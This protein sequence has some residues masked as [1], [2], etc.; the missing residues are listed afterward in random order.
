MISSPRSD[1]FCDW[2]DV[3]CSPDESFVQR[4]SDF[5]DSLMCPVAFSDDRCVSFQV[6]DGVLRLE[7]KHRF[8][9]ASASGGVI[10]YFRAAGVFERY[11]SILSEVPHNVSRLDA[12]VDL[13]T[14]APGVLRQLECR[15]PADLV[16]LTRK[17]LRVTRLYSAR[18]SDGQQTGTWYVGHRSDGKVTARVY[19]KQ[20]QMLDTKG[21]ETP[22]RTRVEMT[23][24]KEVGC[25]LRDAAMPTSL[26]YQYATPAIVDS[27]PDISPWEPN[28]A[29]AWESVPADLL[30]YEVFVRRLESSPELS[31]LIQ[32]ADRFGEEGRATV[33]RA[34]S[35]R[36]A[37][38]SKPTQPEN[39]EA[40]GRRA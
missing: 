10:A 7:A 1:V 11:L 36:L 4:V 37:Q 14:D 31:H 6:G 27:P 22:P 32:L 28:Q 26:F 2:L 16:K 24:R 20:A 29:Y 30:P 33:L 21:L 3:T 15:Y 8:H 19:D 40:H 23:F 12:A 35:T 13:H 9:R 34:F 38:Q 17:A 25:T 5:L 39:V 18:L